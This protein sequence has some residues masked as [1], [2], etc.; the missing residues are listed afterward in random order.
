MK[1]K[2][3]IVDDSESSLEVLTAI[4]SDEGY[5][6]LVADGG[7]EA[8]RIYQH[9]P[10]IDAVLSDFKMPKMDGLQLFKEMNRIRKAPPF[11]IMSAY[12]TV[13]SAVQA[14]KEGVTHYLIKPLDYEE[15][16]ITLENTI[17][18]RETA[19]ELNSIKNQFQKE[20]AFHG[21]IGSDRRMLDVFE[22]VRT[23]GKTDVSVT[24]SGE[25]G[26]GKELLARALHRESSRGESE[27]VCINSA[28]LTEN[29]LEAE[30]FGYV[31]GAFTGADT[32]SKGRLV[33]ADKSTLFLDEIGHMSLRLQTKLLRFLQ[34]K[35][36]EPVGS[37]TSQHVDVRVIA[38]SNLDLQE[39]IEKGQF[40]SDLL[41]R[42]EVINI[43]LPPLRDRREDIY[44]LTQHFI[45]R[46]ARQYE[47]SIQGIDAGA[48]KE[49]SKY[50]WPGNV[51][52]LKNCIARAVILSKKPELCIEDF[53]T[54]IALNKKKNSTLKISQH[55]LNLF[56]EQ[57]N[58][59]DIERM[60]IQI[61]LEKFEGNKSLVAKHLGISRKT[62]YKKLS[63]FDIGQ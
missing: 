27:M 30:L 31:K 43:K 52:E 13:A 17:K 40:L 21:I 12:G 42:L 2:I 60:F 39:Q 54:I 26:T 56:E 1:K 15:L 4:L 45:M 58:L 46:Y 22:M 49:L 6:V 14:L 47:K 63:Q 50:H 62:L 51:R 11:I 38:A 37:T 20:N 24:I 55:A 57:C 33:M 5:D 19:L 25:T 44:L 9:E 29:L 32:S 61:A 41:Y 36:F 18:V 48:M 35:T 59:D 8:L 10:S 7:A 28:A 3:L 34:E 16:S 23:V 53:P